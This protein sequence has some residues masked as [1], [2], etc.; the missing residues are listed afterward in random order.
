[1]DI[2]PLVHPLSGDE[3]K[4]AFCLIKICVFFNLV[5]M[6]TS[7]HR[8]HSLLH[9]APFRVP[10]LFRSCLAPHLVYYPLSALICCQ[11]LSEQRVVYRFCIRQPKT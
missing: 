3:E 2:A 9:T 6:K 1:M 8:F 5:L 4:T 10:H 7:K 11:H